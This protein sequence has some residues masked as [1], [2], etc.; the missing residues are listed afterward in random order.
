MSLLVNFIALLEGNNARSPRIFFGKHHKH[1]LRSGINRSICID[2]I[3]CGIHPSQW[4]DDATPCRTVT[5]T[6][7]LFTVILS[8]VNFSVSLLV[9]FWLLS[10]HSL[11]FQKK[12]SKYI[13]SKLINSFS[14]YDM[15]HGNFKSD[16][17]R[18]FIRGSGHAGDI[19][20]I[21][22]CKPY[23]KYFDEVLR[24]KETNEKSRLVLNTQ[25]LLVKLVANFVKYG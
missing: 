11:H 22:W 6:H 7:L 16:D 13:F 2:E 1:K 24:T 17:I 20:Y 5:S 8:F 15:V 10:L 3:I 23:K 12:K 14:G 4:K 9:S 25:H 21:L 18:R 19:C